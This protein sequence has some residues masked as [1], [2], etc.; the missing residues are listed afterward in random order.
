MQVWIEG[1]GNRTP[2]NFGEEG[3]IGSDEKIGE[4]VATPRDEGDKCPICGFEA[5]LRQVGTG[6]SSK[7]HG[8]M[9]AVSCEACGS[10][11]SLVVPTVQVYPEPDPTPEGIENLPSNIDKYYQEAL[12][13][14]GADAPNA[15]TTM[16]RKVINAVCIDYEV[17]DPEDSDA[18]MI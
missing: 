1:D 15:A 11:M 17:A 10:I 7:E 9:V 14:L 3:Y 8:Y 6:N 5:D 18:F 4:V 12:R 13:C 2:S 16:F